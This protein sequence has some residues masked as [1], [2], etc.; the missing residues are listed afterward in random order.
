M[1]GDRYVMGIDGGGS[2]IRVVVTTYDLRVAG[3]AHGS[4]ANPS[5]VGA[6]GAARVIH[7]AMRTALDAANLTPRDIDAVAL[8]IAGAAAHHSAAWVIEVASA[9]LPEARIVPSAD[10]EIAL[11]GALGER[12]GVL[13]LA[14]TGSLAYGVN[15]AGENAL[16]GGWGYLIDDA[17]GGFWLGKQ[18]I[19]AV[20]RA[21]DGR[22][23]KTVLTERL[24][25]RFELRKP[26]DFVHWLYRSESPRIREIAACA[27]LVLDT[28]ADG[29][30]VAQGIV[31]R[32]C[33]EL[34]LAAQTVI[35][36]LS[37]E[38]AG[39]AFA[40]GLLTNP[41]PLSAAVCNALHLDGIPTP[42]FS[43]VIGAALLARL[44]IE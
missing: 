13:L 28:A 15:A 3:D 41:N 14:G 20:M 42:R 19:E 2:T 27:P 34:V 10:F 17:G 33:D 26:L 22:A 31:D 37:L 29:D 36:R 24:L 9:L 16:V 6:D 40:G 23:P 44:S 38:S 43:P 30:A 35:N 7:E 4:T 32:A 5:V 18:A 8:G 1:A 25:A 11:V 12:R 21:D 39:I